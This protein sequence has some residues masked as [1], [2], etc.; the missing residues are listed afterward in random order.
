[1]P[2]P[3]DPLP[4]I[5]SGRILADLARS[6][7]VVRFAKYFGALVAA[8]I[9]LRA[10]ERLHHES[11]RPQ[12]PQ[13][14]GWDCAEKSETRVP[15]RA[16]ESI[17]GFLVL[18]WLTSTPR[19]GK[20]KE[21]VAQLLIIFAQHLSLLAGSMV[22]RASQNEPLAVVRA[23]S[24]IDEHYGRDLSLKSVA[25]AARLSAAHFCRVFKRTTGFALSQYVTRV[26]VERAK[27]LLQ[28]RR[29][30]VNEVASA[31]GFG[32]I[33]HFNRMFKRVVGDSPSGFRNTEVWEKQRTQTERKIAQRPTV[34]AG[35]N[36]Q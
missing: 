1:M 17:I 20:Q 9:E 3:H 23:R 21:V 5:V 28:D 36:F 8:T 15:V 11:G 6:E 7:L 30:R 33:P 32:S 4:A 34:N 25:H 27:A 10:V 24:F 31:V 14:N 16:N 12:E 2:L 19:S 18:A 29:L 26:R 35:T 22:L 13:T